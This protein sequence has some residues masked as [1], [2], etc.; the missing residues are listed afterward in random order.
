MGLW[1]RRRMLEK[2]FR[3]VVFEYDFGKGCDDGE[4]SR[5]N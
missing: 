1:R 4:K 3:V 2:G 5:F